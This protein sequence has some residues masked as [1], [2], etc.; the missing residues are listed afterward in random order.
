MQIYLTRQNFEALTR[1]RQE[2]HIDPNE[3]INTLL[4]DWFKTRGE[5]KEQPKYR[6]SMAGCSMRFFSAENLADHI[7]R[8]HRQKP[9]TSDEKDEA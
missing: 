4:L 9:L 8:R 1:L 7:A 5:Q 3:L 6:C 2:E